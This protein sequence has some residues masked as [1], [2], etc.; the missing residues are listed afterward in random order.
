MFISKPVTDYLPAG[1][2]GFKKSEEKNHIYKETCEKADELF[3]SVH[4][5]FIRTIL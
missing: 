1:N 5:F 2:C 4:S 3:H